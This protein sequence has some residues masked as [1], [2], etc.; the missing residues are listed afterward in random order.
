M[1]AALAPELPEQLGV[2]DPELQPE[3]VAHLVAP[4][5]L[6]RSRA[7]HQHPPGP[8]THDQLLD[9]EP[10]LDGLAEAHVVGDQ[11][12]DAWHLD[13]ANDG[14]ELVAL[15]LDPAPKRGLESPDVGR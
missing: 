1:D 4:L 2:H 12:A 8:M 3:L 13:G 6:E 11:E 10:R 5:E 15:D 9:H 14:V 7:D